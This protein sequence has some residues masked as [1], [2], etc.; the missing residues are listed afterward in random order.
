M[1]QHNVL[2]GTAVACFVISLALMVR[3][4]WA[5]AEVGV[6]GFSWAQVVVMV[7]IG[8]AWGDMRRQVADLRRDFDE[9]RKEGK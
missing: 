5:A 4:A 2:W 3:P 9:L 8:A 7:G 1:R 6:G